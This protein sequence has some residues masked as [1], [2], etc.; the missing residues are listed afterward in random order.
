M[1]SDSFELKRETVNC[2]TIFIVNNQLR[3]IYGF[4]AR[5]H[6]L[7]RDNIYEPAA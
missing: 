7:I 5:K 2:I 6:I 1:G 3:M 4:I